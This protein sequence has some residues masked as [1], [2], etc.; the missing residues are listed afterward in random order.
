M[1]HRITKKKKKSLDNVILHT[2]IKEISLF[3]F[4]AKTLVTIYVNFNTDS[5]IK[6]FK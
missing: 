5:L 1:N 6:P 2:L 4:L 3:N